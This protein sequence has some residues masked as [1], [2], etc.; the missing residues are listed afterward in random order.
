MYNLLRL[1]TKYG[2]VLLFLILEVLCITLLVNNL[3]YQKR[4]LV[5]FGNSISG[6]FFNA[7]ANLAEYFSLK[8]ENQL[9]H[10]YNAMLMNA[11]TQNV[12]DTSIII[13]TASTTYRFI[14]AKVVNNSIYSVNNYLIIDK[15]KKDGVKKDMVR[16]MLI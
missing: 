11:L 3:P 13:D 12:N 6:G 4:R 16:S 1:I 2:Y 15:G 9:M 10:E 8:E 7:Q 5:S 14:P